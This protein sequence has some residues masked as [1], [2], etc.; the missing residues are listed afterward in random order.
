MFVNK[1]SDVRGNKLMKVGGMCIFQKSKEKYSIYVS[2]YQMGD[3]ILEWDKYT[4]KLEFAKEDSAE[5]SRKPS[6]GVCAA[7]INKDGVEEVYVVNTDTMYGNKNVDDSLFAFD[8]SG[9]KVD[10]LKNDIGVVSNQYSSRNVICMDRYGTETYSFIPCPFGGYLRCFEYESRYEKLKEKDP[11]MLRVKEISKDIGLNHMLYSRSAL[12]MPYCAGKLDILFGNENTPNVFMKNNNHGGFILTNIQNWDMSSENINVRGMAPINIANKN[13]LS[14]LG[15]IIGNWNGAIEVFKKDYSSTYCSFYKTKGVG[16]D[17]NAKYPVRNIVVADFDNDGYDEVFVHCY[18]GENVLY[19]YR[20]ETEVFEMIDIGD[21]TEKYGFGTSCV[22]GDID[23]DGMLE[24]ILGH[25]EIVY[26]TISFYKV[27]PKH[28]GNRW[29]RIH[30]KTSYDSPARGA[31]VTI[32]LENGKTR[33]RVIDCGSGYLSQNEPVAHFG[34]GDYG[35]KVEVSIQWT[36]GEVVEYGKFDVNKNVI[37]SKGK[38]AIV[39]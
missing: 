12:V 9:N 39:M 17:G 6:Y 33:K 10:Y 8:E 18:G 14:E 28:E 30:P 15:I 5:D 13:G 16:K 24:L 20:D 35:K 29:I 21:A 32:R 11:L 36:D 27:N 2:G 3:S 37:I 1:T 31:V 19:K 34:L 38:K 4:K 23:N 7:D 26:Q 22:V 25:G